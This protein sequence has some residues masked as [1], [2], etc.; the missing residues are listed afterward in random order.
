MTEVLPER[1]SGVDAS[2][3]S[4]ARGYGVPLA[5]YACSRV[6]I[7]LVTIVAHD[8]VH[9]SPS[10][11]RFVTKWDAGFYVRI[12]KHGYASH[13]TRVGGV[14][15]PSEHAFLPGYPL[16]VR[17]VDPV[18]PGGTAFAAVI[19]ALAGG[20]VATV[21]LWRLA[22]R[23]VGDDAADRAVL[24]FCFFPGTLVFNWPYSE[25]VMLAFIVGALLLLLDGRWLLAAALTLVA[26]ATRVNALPVAVA[27]A[28][29]AWQT[30]G[31]AL[32]A[33]AGRAAAALAVAA[34]GF[35]AF[36]VWVG[37]HVHEH[38]A[39]FRMERDVWHEGQPWKRFPTTLKDAIFDEPTFARVV[40]VLFFV[41]VVVFVWAVIGAHQPA[42]MKFVSYAA[43]VMA[44][45]A[46]VAQVS[47][48][49]QLA[50]VPAFIALAERLRGLTLTLWIAASAMLATVLVFAYGLPNS[51]HMFAP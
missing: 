43:L 34:S 9:P 28:W 27:C 19:V 40:T 42:W 50:A 29:V 44:V 46:N 22:A 16:L 23:L 49:L 31:R 30:G 4:W 45:G 1:A 48:R 5:V 39:W 20:A 51:L 6:L 3:R 10:L 17:V 32:A 13:L 35:V 18:L 41:I 26:A 37:F 21:L 33:R 25:G 11:V 8:F 47:P 36:V 7:F 24:L 12:A 2:D 14:L 38:R 15:Q